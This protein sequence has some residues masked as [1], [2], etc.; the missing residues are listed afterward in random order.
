[1]R[2]WSGQWRPGEG[3]G[4]PLPA[5]DGPSTLV[6]VFASPAVIADDTP[7]DPGGPLAG[8]LEA[9]P[10]S[11][12]MGCSTAGEILGGTIDDATVSVAVAQFASTRLRLLTGPIGGGTDSAAVGRDL[13]ARLVAAEPDLAGVF[14]LSDGLRANGAQLAQGLSDGCAGTAVITGGLAGDGD[15]FDHTWVLVDGRPRTGMVSVLGLSGPHV[16]VGHGA[17]GGWSILGPERLVT[18]AE[19]NVVHELD[20]QPALTLYRSYLGDR[21]GDT[22]ASTLMFPLSVRAPEGRQGAVVRTVQALDESAQSLVFTGDV[23]QGSIAR[24][25]RANTGELVDGAGEAVRRADLVPGL[26]TLALVVSCVGRRA[27]L[28]QRTEDELEM[29]MSRLPADV[30]LAGFYSYG[31]IS[32][33]GEHTSGLL[34]QTLT[35]TTIQETAA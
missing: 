24:L 4:E 7:P 32:P 11:V 13:A 27:V 26:P 28:G 16:R 17:G 18:R 10:A 29:V 30:H 6:L 1:M 12:V 14:V 9:Y 23:P 21:M 31:E 2:A 8:L 20:G 35:V 19:G 33:I 3:F 5:W 15:R 34:N 25:L 22:A